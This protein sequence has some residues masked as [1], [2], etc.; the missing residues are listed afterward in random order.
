MSVAVDKN[1]IC[2]FYKLTGDGSCRG[3]GT[4]FFFMEND[5]VATCKH[6]M[7]DHANAQVPYGLLIRPSQ[8]SEGCLAVE[9]VYHIEQDLAL[10]RLAKKYPV[11]PF[12]PCMST[13][14]GFHYIGYDPT[15]ESMIV[16]HTPTFFTP[17]PWEGKRSNMF[18]FE[19]NG[20]LNP[21]NSGGPLIGSDGGVAGILT[22]VSRQVESSDDARK[23][24]GRA[25]AVYIGPLTELYV[26][27]KNN[28]ESI[29]R[30]EVPFT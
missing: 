5:L 14:G 11:A 10:V 30:L 22:G 19:W 17:D 4:G 24:P 29:P 28:P 25:R 16:R 13:D 8:S 23:E 6:I 27:W 12:R 9:C 15:T 7:E 1:A 26:G 2:I 20:L 21:G 3:I 18:L